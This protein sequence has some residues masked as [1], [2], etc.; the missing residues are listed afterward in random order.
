M[1]KPGWVALAA[2]LAITGV[3]VVS[4]AVLRAQPPHPPAATPASHQLARP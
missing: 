3:A 4:A 1:V 2:I